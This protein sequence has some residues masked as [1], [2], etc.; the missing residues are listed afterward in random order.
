MK[1]PRPSELC[2]SRRAALTSNRAGTSAQAGLTREIVLLME[3]PGSQTWL[4]TRSTWRALNKPPA[5]LPCPSE[6]EAVGLGNGPALDFSDLLR[7]SEC[8]ASGGNP[9]RNPFHTLL[10]CLLLQKAKEPYF[11]G[12]HSLPDRATLSPQHGSLK[13]NTLPSTQHSCWDPWSVDC[14]PEA[15]IANQD[16]CAM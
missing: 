13:G 2:T 12:Q 11:K 14:E 10:Y 7:T 6:S 1:T 16:P 4:H 3:A 15:G 9:G 5:R 8:A